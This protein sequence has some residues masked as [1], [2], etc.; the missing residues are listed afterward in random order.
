M[1][2]DLALLILDVQVSL[3]D[4]PDNYAT[5][6]QLYDSLKMAQGYVDSIKDPL[7]IES[8]EIKAIRS[9]ATYFAYVNYTSLVERTRGEVSQASSIKLAALQRIAVS[10]LRRITTLTINDDT[11]VDQTASS[12]KMWAAVGMTKSAVG[13]DTYD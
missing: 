11:T 8:L 3:S 13:S 6:E 10:F 12:K 7:T 1:A 9:L 5:D 4:I 2:V